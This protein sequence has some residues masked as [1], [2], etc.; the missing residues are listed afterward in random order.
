MRNILKKLIFISAGAF[1]FMEL[2]LRLAGYSFPILFEASDRFGY[3]LKPNQNIRFFGRQIYVN[4]YGM[5]TGEISPLPKDGIVR[6]LCV[7]DSITYGGAYTD[8]RFTYPQRLQ[9]I[10]N[11]LRGKMYEVINVSAPGWSIQNE[12]A[13]LRD[14]GIYGSHIVVIQIGTNDFFQEKVGREV[15]GRTYNF[16]SKKPICI[17]CGM[18]TKVFFHKQDFQT[19]KTPKD[20]LLI[21]N[22]NAFRD[23]LDLIRAKG[24]QPVVLFID[25]IMA[26][27]GAP[28]DTRYIKHEFMDVAYECGAEFIDMTA[29][30]K[31]RKELF[32]DD[33]HP[34]K[35]GN[36]A[37]AERLKETVVKMI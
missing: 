32:H 26:S 14:R 35:S 13:Y 6:V 1:I 33:I 28:G 25:D 17:S 18:I 2:A 34:N 16:P 37:I 31:G 15:V 7:G 10:L 11:S 23:M 5:R 12:L 36:E 27:A 22:L 20:R 24:A 9:D 29:D 21:A 3:A 8:Q 19:N 30:L 4:S